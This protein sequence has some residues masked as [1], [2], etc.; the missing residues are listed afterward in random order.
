MW[1]PIRSTTTLSKEL[2]KALGTNNLAAV[3]VGARHGRRRIEVYW[4]SPVGKMMKSEFSPH[5]PI[6]KNMFDRMVDEIRE[7]QDVEWYTHNLNFGL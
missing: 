2:R 7:L 1:K 4:T 5:Y 6:S 3:R